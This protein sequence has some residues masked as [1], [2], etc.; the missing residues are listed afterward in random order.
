[1]FSSSTVIRPGISVLLK[2]I[3]LSDGL[4]EKAL[5]ESSSLAPHAA[6]ELATEEV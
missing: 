5:G 3:E 1:M 4:L 2:V 6:L